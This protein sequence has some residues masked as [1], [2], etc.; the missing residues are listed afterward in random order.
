[1]T[2]YVKHIQAQRRL[3]IL[4]LLKESGGQLNEKIIETALVDR[5]YPKL[6][7]KKIRDDL[8]YLEDRGT[9]EREF[10]DD[11]L[12]VKIHRRGIDVANG[13]EN[14]KGVA[15]PFAGL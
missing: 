10:L 7:R 12:V 15:E 11:L 4:Q 14:V 5:G 13:S 1:M 2:E 6:S 8:K 3:E 9:L